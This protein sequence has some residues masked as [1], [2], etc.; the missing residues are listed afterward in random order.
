M[1]PYRRHDRHGCHLAAAELLT[2][3]G[4]GEIFAMA[5]H[6]V[7]SVQAIDRIKNS[8]IAERVVCTNTLPLKPE[9]LIDKIE[10]S[11]PWR[12]SSRRAVSTRSSVTR[13]Q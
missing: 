11:C 1:R 6:G 9:K 4:A 7:F 5:T 8:V 12:R 3:P 2:D 13:A 10:Q